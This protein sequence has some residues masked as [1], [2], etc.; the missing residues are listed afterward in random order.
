[1]KN[2]ETDRD[3]FQA[4]SNNLY[5]SLRQSES[6]TLQLAAE[7]QDYLRFNQTR[8]RQITH[9]EQIRLSMRFQSKGRRVAFSLDLTND[10][11]ADTQTLLS[12]LDRAREESKVLPEDPFLSPF[13]NHGEHHEN[14]SGTLPPLAELLDAM[15]FYEARNID[16]VGLYAGGSLLRATTNSEGLH[17]S[18]SSDSF[19]LDYSI[20][21]L[22]IAGENKAVKG[23]YAG[24]SWSTPVFHEKMAAGEAQ[25]PVLRSA[26]KR[27]EP[28]RYRVFFSP[29]AVDAL[30]GMFSWG[31]V[32]Y[33][34]Y[35]QGE[36]ALQKLIEGEVRLSPHF[37]LEEDFGLSLA[38]RF[39]SVGEIAPASLPIITDGEVKNLLISSRTAREYGLS[40][41][42]ADTAEAL[43]S[44]VM[45]PGNLAS[46]DILR[47]LGTGLYLSNLH[48][49][50]WS[51]RLNARFTGMTRY[52]CFWVEDGQVVAPIQ[53]LRF[54]ESLFTLFGSGLEAVTEDAEIIMATDT[55]NQ[56]SLGGTKVPGILVD[57]VRFTL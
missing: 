39:N 40:G 19:F 43:R 5:S 20:F 9:V 54:D 29:K 56:R 31:G 28:G 34:A 51:D 47:R 55:Y 12:L 18:F 13:E 8:I 44:P 21:T 25:L 4:L 37:R 50:N 15:G 10:L 22:N 26:S 11:D 42:S 45:A 53:D 17:Q 57:G 23:L 38:P 30:I 27:L 3:L 49:L 16:L 6:M 14:H 36:S 48:Y 7:N 41:N 2:T 1:M 52:A 35:R 46:G 32:S 24:Q 33:A